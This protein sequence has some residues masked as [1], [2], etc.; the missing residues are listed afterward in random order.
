MQHPSRF[1]DKPLPSGPGRVH[2]VDD[3]P[4]VL[5]SL[6]FLLE[7]D[8][9]STSRNASAEELLERLEGSE[10][11]ATEACVITDLAMPGQSGLDLLDELRRR[12]RSLPTLIVTGHGDVPT[13]VRAIKAGCTDFLQKPYGDDAV[14]EAVQEM[15]KPGASADRLRPSRLAVQARLATLS[16]RELDVM[17]AVVGGQSNREIAAERDLSPKTVEAHRSRVMVKMRA[18]SFAA[19]VR[20]ASAVGM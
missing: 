16:P 5:D 12:G 11:A 7:A 3:D 10:A 2:V 8:G 6:C 17:R 4:A 9:F 18:E 1:A 14:L 20:M 15:F 19:L 13:A